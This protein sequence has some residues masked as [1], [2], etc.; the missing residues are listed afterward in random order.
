MVVVTILSSCATEKQVIATGGELPE[1]TYSFDGDKAMRSA[2]NLAHGKKAEI[3][4]EL[5]SKANL[6]LGYWITRQFRNTL[7]WQ[8][9]HNKA[10]GEFAFIE[11]D[12]LA[13]VS[14]VN[15]INPMAVVDGCTY[16][17]PFDSLGYLN[18]FAEAYSKIGVGYVKIRYK[19]PENDSL[20]QWDD[21]WEAD[22]VLVLVE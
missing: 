16:T 7:S 6:I 18:N 12:E 3:C 21:A 20:S 17:L 8:V 2:N 15:I 13:F 10:K 1:L 11:D 22:V 9:T 19:V 5:S 4:P 14:Q